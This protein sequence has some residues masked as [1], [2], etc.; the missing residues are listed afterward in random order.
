MSQHDHVEHN[1]EQLHQSVVV[2]V[3]K[4][5]LLLFL[6]DS[7]FLLLLLGFTFLGNYPNLHHHYF[8]LL[9]VSQI[10]KYVVLTF[11]ALWLVTT[12]ASRNIYISG[13]HLVISNGIENR[14]QTMHELQQ[15]RS[16]EMRQSWLGRQMKY[17]TI[18]LTFAVSGY[19]RVVVLADMAHP[20]ACA[21]EIEKH[22]GQK[23]INV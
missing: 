18:S 20:R 8:V 4:L 16:V 9:V 2:L 3:M 23:E 5:A 21:D 11:M 17:G 12:W 10:I 14:K 19:K 13:H 15:L 7:A 22:L 1:V 6:L